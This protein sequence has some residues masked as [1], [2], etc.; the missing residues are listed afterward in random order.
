MINN[1]SIELN[2]MQAEFDN[3]Y[4]ISKN[5]QPLSGEMPILKNID[6]YGEV[7]PFNKIAGGDHIIY[8]DFNQRYDLKHRILKAE[9][10]SDYRIADNLKKCQHKAGILLADAAGHNIT[11]VILT[12]ML[13]QAFL[14]GIQY[15]LKKNGEISNE[16]F[17]IL[18]TRFFNS[19]SLSKFITLIYGEIN[20]N[21]KFR[22]IS[23]GH[24]SP[25][26]F[27][28]K[29]N[30]LFKIDKKNIVHFPPIGT[31]PSK[32][33]IDSVKNISRFGYKKKYAANEIELMGEGDILLLYTDG[34]S[35]HNRDMNEFYLDKR[36]EETLIRIK[37]KNAKDICTEINKDLHEFANPTDDLSF[38]IV[39]KT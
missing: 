31:L 20:E 18:N 35:E 30:K 26:V 8:I 36:L 23:A 39:K 24:P 32:E 28:N 16:L 9:N 6:I 7:I 2:N 19:S 1:K 34:F 21:G 27:S 17:E 3:L 5:L 25:L 10:N 33:D 38:V 29:K 22:F 11:D 15:E 12:A 4:K 13:H 14:T 37:D